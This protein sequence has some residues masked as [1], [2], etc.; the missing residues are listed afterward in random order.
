MPG[1]AS[2]VDEAGLRYLPWLMLTVA[3]ALGF[4]FGQ[5]RISLSAILVAAATYSVERFLFHEPTLEAQAP[6]ILLA[7]LCVLPGMA[8]LY[9]FGEKGLLTEHGALRIGIVILGCMVMTW[10]PNH[11]DML[12]S[13]WGRY[14]P[15][16][17]TISDGFA[18]P[19]IVVP[20][21][22][23]CLPLLVIGK[24]QE[25]PLLGPL[26]GIAMLF[27]VLAMNC[28][29]TF[30]EASQQHGGL[31][32]MISGGGAALAWAV[33]EGAWRNAN[34]DELTQL[35][36]RRALKRHLARMGPDC[37]IALMD[38]D[39]FKKVNDRH[40]H[41]VGD[42]V[43]RFVASHIRKHAPGIAYR[44][45]GEEFVIVCE[46]DD[47]NGHAEALDEMREQLGSLKFRLRGRA[48]PRRRPENPES[49]DAGS[50]GTIHVT[51]SMGVAADENGDLS[52]QELIKL[53]DKALY[54]AKKAGRDRLSR[55]GWKAK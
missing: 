26:M 24:R 7:L 36:A 29:T 44:Y 17:R 1:F 13:L 50:A 3:V 46:G 40:G 51:A 32:L 39:H 25:S 28:R 47:H 53:A 5:T 34:I 42:Q 37:T 52:P 8:L 38:I 45:G 23:V 6:A 31:M 30:W 12:R 55:T 2:W 20:Q 15:L 48:R 4:A 43:L 18:L 21:L 16:L 9:L 27:F 19:K 41:D 33:L 54:R 14:A 35:P 49:G 11:P 22:L 10:L